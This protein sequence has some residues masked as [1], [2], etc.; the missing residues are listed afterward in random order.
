[1]DWEIPFVC[2]CPVAKLRRYLLGAFMDILHLVFAFIWLGSMQAIVTGC[3]LGI[4][5]PE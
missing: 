5:C 3:V 4:S 1:M 2:F